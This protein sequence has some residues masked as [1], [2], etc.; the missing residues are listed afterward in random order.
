[1]LSRNWDGFA[2]AYERSSAART[3]PLRENASF[4]S[5]SVFFKKPA[6]RERN[7]LDKTGELVIPERASVRTRAETHRLRI[8]ARLGDLGYRIRSLLSDTHASSKR[9]GR[10]AAP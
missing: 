8:L 4:F 5:R 7:E 6:Q 10:S 1:M 3:A 9:G 2:S